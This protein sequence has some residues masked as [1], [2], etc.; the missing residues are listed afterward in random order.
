V[1]GDTEETWGRLFSTMNQRYQEPTLV[2]FT[3]SVSSACG[4]NSA[5]SGP[6]YCP[7]DRQVY[8]DLSFFDQLERRFGAPGD[9]AQAYLIAHEVGHHVQR[10]LGISDQVH[11]AKQRASRTQ[12]NELS[13]RQE[14]QADCFAG[15]WGHHAAQRGLLEAGDLQEAMTAAAAI[16]DDTIQRRS[17][18]RVVPESWTH[19]S[20]EQRQRWLAKGL[21]S[22]DPAVCE[23]FN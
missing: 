4:Y 1:L 8:V 23:T 10:L 13:V 20:S 9:I 19:G 17:T 3:G 21:E 7:A 16:G 14:L 12:A 2:L 6:F 15:V 18:G 11:Q 5:A 22:G